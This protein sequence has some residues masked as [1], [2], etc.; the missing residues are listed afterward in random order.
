MEE[1]KNKDS[2]VLWDLTGEL[3]HSLSHREL[4]PVGE[5]T[6]TSKEA[7]T[8]L[9]GLFKEIVC[10]LDDRMPDSETH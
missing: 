10:L 1:L 7:T 8:A 4:I 3:S 2:A 9:Y 6:A 5:R